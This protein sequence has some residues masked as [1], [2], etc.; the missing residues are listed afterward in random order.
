[1]SNEKW[2]INV[3]INTHCKWSQL[4]YITNT[5]QQKGEY[6]AV[7]RT[8]FE[9]LLDV[10]P[11][12]G[13]KV[14]DSSMT[15]KTRLR[16]NIYRFAWVI[17]IISLLGNGG[18]FDP[19][20]NSCP[21]WSEGQCLPTNVQ[22][23]LQS[24]AKRLLQGIS[25]LWALETLEPTTDE[26]LREYFVDLDVSLSEGHEYVPIGHMEDR[27]DWSLAPESPTDPPQTHSGNDPLIRSFTKATIGPQAPIGTIPSQTANELP[28][29][30]ATTGRQAQI[31]LAPPQTA[32]EPSLTQSRG[33]NDGAV[34]LASSDGSCASMKKDGGPSHGAS[35]EHDDADDGQHHELSVHID[36]DV[37]GADGEHVTH[38]DEAMAV[39][40]TLQSDD[41]EREHVHLPESII[42]A[43]AGREGD[44]DSVVAKGEHLP[45]ADAFFEATA[46]AIILYHQSTPDAVETRSSSPKSYAVHH[47]DQGDNF[48]ITLEDP[49]EEMPSEHIDV[50]LSLLCKGMTGLKSKLY[51]TH[52]CVVDTT[53]F[54]TMQISNELRGYV[55]AERP[56][57]GKK[58]EDV[59]FILAPCN[60][61]GHWVV[62]KIDL[63]RWTIKVLDSVRTSDAKDNGVRAGQMTPLMTMMP[64]I[65]DQAGYFNN[66]CRKRR[67]LMPMPL[68]IHLPKAKVHQQNDSV[69]C[70]MFMIGSNTDNMKI[71]TIYLS[72]RRGFTCSEAYKLRNALGGA[73]A[74]MPRSLKPREFSDFMQRVDKPM[75]AS[76]EVL[77]KLYWATINLTLQE[78]SKFDRR[79]LWIDVHEHSEARTL[80]CI[81]LPYLLESP[82]DV[83]QLRPLTMGFNIEYG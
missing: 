76:L 73:L 12:G 79:S 38:V 41:V 24:E 16:Y 75:C 39:D 68:D 78:R 26:A 15:K 1:M 55:E 33:V 3:T 58:W 53:F 18:N 52:A 45:L 50:C 28:F 9:M 77:G 4:H 74:K 49:N 11:Q 31:G 54:A 30:E 37:L 22:M 25:E 34:L 62:A 67:D 80:H 60:V 48:F 10:Y 32:N 2:V 14:P 61:G 27:L 66:R 47:G 71:L 6:D 23:R 5:L 42:N 20:K 43:F 7:K 8:C 63:V 29:T 35:L 13:S 19:L 40:V 17:Q 82:Y 70:S 83:M 46:G 57:Y 44:P 69:S 36:D 56:T 51:T 72:K 81:V 59:D 64:I 21:F 65:W